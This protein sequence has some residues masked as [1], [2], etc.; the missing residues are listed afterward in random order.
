MEKVV[1][2]LKDNKTSLQYKVFNAETEDLER[3]HLYNHLVNATETVKD[4]TLPWLPSVRDIARI[5]AP[6]IPTILKSIFQSDNSSVR[7][8]EQELGV[9]KEEQRPEDDDDDEVSSLEIPNL[10]GIREIAEILAD[11]GPLPD[12]ENLV[13]V[14]KII[15]RLIPF[16]IADYKEEVAGWLEGTEVRD[17]DL[18]EVH[19]TLVTWHHQLEEI[20]KSGLV[21]GVVDRVVGVI[22]ENNLGLLT[23]ILHLMVRAAEADGSVR[24]TR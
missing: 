24:L 16:V 11:P 20:K 21:P 12:V 5:S 17:T 2:I 19:E 6:E 14:S 3:F 9:N 8:E 10:A 13:T 18:A 23:T 1:E 4:M 15:P 22:Q 7:E